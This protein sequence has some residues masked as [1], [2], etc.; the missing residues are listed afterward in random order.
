LPVRSQARIDWVRG[1]IGSNWRDPELYAELIGRG[2]VGLAWEVLR[3]QPDYDVLREGS[4]GAEACP[5]MLQADVRA[6]ARWG[7]HFR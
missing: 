7:L 6:A 2:R 3:R 1:L 5:I 4:A